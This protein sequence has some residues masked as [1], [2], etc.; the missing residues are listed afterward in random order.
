MRDAFKLVDLREP[1]GAVNQ[2]EGLGSRPNCKAE[3]GIPIRGSA[4][5]VEFSDI[6][7]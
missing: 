5:N 6:A 1:P 4:E 7:A 3:V 2:V